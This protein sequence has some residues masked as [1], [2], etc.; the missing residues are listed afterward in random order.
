VRANQPDPNTANNTAS[1]T[2]TIARSV[3]MSDVSIAKYGFDDEGDVNTPT[4]GDP[5]YYVLVV[6]NAGPSDATNVVVTDTLPAGATFNW[7]HTTQG[8]CTFASGT[9]T[10]TIPTLV[11]QGFKSTAYVLV[12]VT[13]T[14]TG[15]ISNTATVRADQADPNPANNSSTLVSTVGSQQQD[16]DDQ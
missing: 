3:Q 11:S 13:P 8:T 14:R 15:T 10:C 16:T 4:V 5:F 6:H 12:S 1:V 9:V 7:V 2:T